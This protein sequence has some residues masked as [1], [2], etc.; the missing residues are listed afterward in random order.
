MLT[1]LNSIPHGM[2]DKKA[3]ELHEYLPGPT[4][5]SL[6][7][8]NKQ[9]LFLSILLHGNEDSGWEALRDLLKAYQDQPLPRA[10]FIFIGNVLAAAKGLRKLDSQTDFNRVWGDSDADEA[11]VMQ[12]VLEEVSGLDLFAS[13]DIHNNTGLNPHYACINKLQPEFV[14]LAKGFSRSIVYFVRPQGVQSIAFSKFCPAVTLECGQPGDQLGIEKAKTF[15]TKLLLQEKLAQQMPEKDDFNLFHTTAIIKIPE[16]YSFSFDGSQADIEFIQGI[17]RH[18]FEEIDSGTPL[19]RI[20][21]GVDLPFLVLEESGEDIFNDF[22]I[23][24]D[25][26]LFTRKPMMPSMLT[27]N[28]TIVRQDCLCYLMERYQPEWGEKII[29]DKGKSWNN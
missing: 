14:N 27:D 13:V 10:L 1:R 8:L 26:Q 16:Q 24:Q 17:E 23:L 2:L 12:T 18:N 15:I 6:E 3:H 28:L 25:G 21:S 29:Q 22:F 11:I 7:G 19:A 4:L 9:P 20:A 5:I